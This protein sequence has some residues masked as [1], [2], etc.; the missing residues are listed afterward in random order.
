MFAKVLKQY[1]ER[2]GLTR[3]ELAGRIGKSPQFVGALEHIESPKTPSLETLKKLICVLAEPSQRDMEGRQVSNALL[4][5]VAADLA[6]AALDLGTVMKAEPDAVTLDE[7]VEEQATVKEGARIWILS[8]RLAEALFDE[9]AEKTARTI[10][11]HKAHYVYFVPFRGWKSHWQVAIESL[12]THLD[13]SILHD[14]VTVYELS[15]CAFGCRLRITNPHSEN[16]TARYSLGAGDQSDLLYY[17]APMELIVKTVETLS[18]I[19]L[20]EKHKHH[21]SADGTVTDP[22]LG[23]IRRVFPE[24]RASQGASL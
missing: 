15:D 12:R 19:C 3:A 21:Q 4:R 18:E 13:T 22:Q 20:L 7:E 9:I 1:R 16:R 11:Q 14:H 23:S 5:R 8:D 10:N 17:P 24:R 6:L 2:A